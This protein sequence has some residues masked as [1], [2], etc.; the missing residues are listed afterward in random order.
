MTNPKHQHLPLI[1]VDDD[2]AV[3]SALGMLLLSRGLSVQTFASG[4][5]FLESARLDACGCVVLDLRMGSISG[6]QVFDALRAR[7]SPL[8]V[9][10]LSGH[11]DIPIATQAVKDGA[12]GWLEKPCGDD[13]LLLQVQLALELAAARHARHQTRTQARALWQRLTPREMEV[14]RLVAEGKS[15]KV[16]ARELV[17]PTDP[18]TVETHRGH[19]V[20]KLKLPSNQWDRLIREHEL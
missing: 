18:R 14:V 17:P 4:E 3:R 15:S 12:F 2:D 10:F 16:V 8:V 7:A 1:V 9:L 20:A 13:A 19:A 11:G 6:L 5:Q